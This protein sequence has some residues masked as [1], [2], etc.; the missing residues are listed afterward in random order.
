M[1]RPQKIEETKEIESKEVPVAVKET[2]KSTVDEIVFSKPRENKKGR[3][4]SPQLRKFMDEESKMVRG[5]FI[6]VEYPGSAQKITYQKY[7]E[8][9]V[10][11]KV[12][13]DG[14]M[15]TIPL[16]VARFINGVDITAKGCGGKIHTCSYPVHEHIMQ[17]GKFPTAQYDSDGIAVPILT[18]I[19]R[20]SRYRFESM[21]FDITL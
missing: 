5:R 8:F 16:W 18:K 17:N 4:I 1:A 2:E 15:Y 10:F 7:P 21:E 19:N 14:E 9:G 6:N 13:M 12:M 20:K 3:S 11:E